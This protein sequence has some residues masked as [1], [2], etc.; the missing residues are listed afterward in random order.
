[1]MV[2]R[3]RQ[4]NFFN[5]GTSNLFVKQQKQLLWDGLPAAGQKMTG[6]SGNH[7]AVL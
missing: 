3:T 6:S 7:C 4:S 1:M 2:K 5:T